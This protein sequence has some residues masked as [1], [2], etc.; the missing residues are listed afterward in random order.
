LALIK[1]EKGVKTRLVKEHL[2]SV[3]CDCDA[4]V[5]DDWQEIAVYTDEF[6]SKWAEK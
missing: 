2:K 3:K 4:A 5:V 6:K 1:M